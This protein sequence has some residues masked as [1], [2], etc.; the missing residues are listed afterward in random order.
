MELGWGGWCAAIAAVVLTGISK[1]GFGGALGGLAVPVLALWLPVPQAVGVM[2]PV[3]I[4]MDV[5]GWRAWRNAACKA[6]LVWLIPAALVGIAMGSWLLQVL[7]LAWS[8]WLIGALAFVFGLDRLWQQCRPTLTKQQPVQGLWALA[9]GT[10]SGLSSALAHAGGPPAMYYLLRRGLAKNT[11]VATL[12]VLFTGINLAKLPFY[13][14]MGLVTLD[15][16]MYSLLLLPCVPIGV[17]LGVKLLRRV[18]DAWFV[19][20]AIAAMLGTGGHLLWTSSQQLW[21][22]VST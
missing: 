14:T 20:I 13:L 6:D 18:P 11:L 5:V 12:V 7:S 10:A 16:L 9:C 19:G 3:L 21:W 4:A 8:Q 17:W 22:P 15:T 1:S 2:L